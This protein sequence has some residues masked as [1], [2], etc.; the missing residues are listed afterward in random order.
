MPIT[1]YNQIVRF[2]QMCGAKI[3]LTISQTLTPIQNDLEAVQNFG[4]EYAIQQCSELI[5]NGVRGIHFYT[6]NRS[7]S[8]HAILNALHKKFPHLF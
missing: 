4:I 1:N 3:P 8:S 2:A 5:E 6:L 7:R